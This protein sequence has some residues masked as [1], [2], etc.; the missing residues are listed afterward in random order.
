MQSISYFSAVE[1]A[2]GIPLGIPPL[3]GP[4]LR[5]IYEFCDALLLP[6][7]MDLDP[8]SY[9]AGPGPE[10]EIHPEL[11]LA[12]LRLT[13]WA[14]EDRLPLLGVCRGA[15]LLNVALGG[16]LWRDLPSECHTYIHDGTGAGHRVNPVPGTRLHDLLG[17]GA[18]PANS[19]HHQA[20]RLPG[21]GLQVSAH[22]PDGI[23]EAIESTDPDWFA[24]GV[25]WHPEELPAGHP[26]GSL[27][28]VRALL[29]AAE[30]LSALLSRP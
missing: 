8:A 4:D 23:P 12:E 19:R 25:Q 18:L 21:T 13:R 9:G 17:S 30:P 16:S 6:G 11:D 22:A 2:G 27:P 5:V 28:L 3:A 10:G 29:A 1:A 24:M 26:A 20:V 14:R 7:G 15:Q